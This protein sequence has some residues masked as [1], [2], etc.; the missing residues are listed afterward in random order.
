MIPCP[1]CRSPARKGPCPFC[2]ALVAA[3]LVL[4]G[5][6]AAAQDL[7]PMYGMPMIEEPEP[8]PEAPRTGE[9]LELAARLGQ[10]TPEELAS[11]GS[12]DDEASARLRLAHAKA[13]GNDAAMS[14]ALRDLHRLV[15]TD[16]EVPF[17]LAL[18]ATLANDPAQ[19]LSWSE[20]GLGL[21]DHWDAEQ[22]DKRALMLHQ[23]A[24]RAAAALSRPEPA[25]EHAL[26]AIAIATR[27]GSR[28]PD[29]L[30]ELGKPAHAPG[31]GPSESRDPESRGSAPKGR[32]KR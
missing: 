6:T 12:R 13:T 17:E 28:V 27:I 9:A 16:P 31:P 15:P 23:Q 3:G 32:K 18:L 1:L 25:R 10:L 5:Q 20:V 26:A 2:G 8:A 19:I 22:R 30:K 21:L 11:L 7:E 14:A 24:A 4:L 29:D